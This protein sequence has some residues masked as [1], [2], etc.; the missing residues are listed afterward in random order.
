MIKKI[1][2]GAKDTVEKAA[3]DTAVKLN[4]DRGG[5]I[6]S[7]AGRTDPDIVQSYGLQT[8]LPTETK[9]AFE[10][11]LQSADGTL[12][13]TRS[14]GDGTLQHMQDTA[15]LHQ[16]PFLIIDLRKTTEFEAAQDINAWC[17][18]FQ[19]ES[20]HVVGQ[21]GDQGPVSY[22]Q[23]TN[24]IETAIYMGLI[25]AD[26]WQKTAPPP[27]E[28]P[29]TVDQAVQMLIKHLSL[30]DRATIANMTFSEL[31]P[32]QATL[33]EYIIYNFGLLE[34]TS[35]LLQSCRFVSGE[36]H[37]DPADANAASRIIITALWEEL[38]KTHKLRIIK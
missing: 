4:L 8:L 7:N 12:V 15:T 5:F 20:L 34:K 28:A 22:H 6:P 24:I 10:I 27:R 21:L 26:F 35:P 1:I 29:Q 18:S 11:N 14:P 33:G 30:K 13:I 3:L 31:P 32:L 23:A 9:S 25:E 37:M 19:L 38:R 16:K 2:S 36:K 17:E